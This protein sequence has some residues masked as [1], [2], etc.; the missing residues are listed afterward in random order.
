MIENE[1][2]L[3]KNGKS[4]VS[5]ETKL[6]SVKGKVSRGSIKGDLYEVSGLINTKLKGT[7]FADSKGN[8][9]YKD[10]NES[11]EENKKTDYN[12]V[13]GNT[14]KFKVV[15]FELPSG[16]YKLNSKITGYFEVEGYVTGKYPLAIQLTDKHGENIVVRGVL[17][18][19][20]GET[21]ISQFEYKFSEEE[22]SGYYDVYSYLGSHDYE[23]SLDK[24]FFYGSGI[25]N[26]YHNLHNIKAGKARTMV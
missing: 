25:W 23:F 20:E 12:V 24:A 7:F 5:G 18:V 10:E 11:K 3:S 26:Y 16:G 2:F 8:V 6:M 15:G 9:Y 19:V 21:T 1:E 14:D 22:A 17:D 4:S 13:E